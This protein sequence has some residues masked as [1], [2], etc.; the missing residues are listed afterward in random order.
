MRRPGLALAL[1]SVLVCAVPVSAGADDSSVPSAAQLARLA[2]Q[3]GPIRRHLEATLA[4]PLV[5]VTAETL[6]VSLEGSRG[7]VG[8]PRFTGSH[9]YRQTL[10]LLA[11]AAVV[12]CFVYLKALNLA[13]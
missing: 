10:L 8:S 13:L 5:G 12:I 4:T 11:V 3:R 9:S 1:S 2:A 6:G 7:S